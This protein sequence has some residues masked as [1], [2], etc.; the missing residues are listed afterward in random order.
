M[1]NYIIQILSFIVLTT[2]ALAQAEP[3]VLDVTLTIDAPFSTARIQA[4]GWGGTPEILYTAKDRHTGKEFQETRPIAAGEMAALKRLLIDNDFWSF[5]PEYKEEDLMD[6]I[7]YSVTAAWLPASCA[8]P[9]KRA[10][11]DAA[12]TTV[13]CYGECPDK[14]VEIQ[15]FIRR[16]WNGNILEKGI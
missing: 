13:S 15:N 11:C 4:K 12:H 5:E 9:D 2:P 3:I 7:T 6:A 16:L 1:R 10:L 14:I 8:A